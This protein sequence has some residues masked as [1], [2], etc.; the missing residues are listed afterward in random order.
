M[1]ELDKVQQI[2]NESEKEKEGLKAQLTF[3]IQRGERLLLE[4]RENNGVLVMISITLNDLVSGFA[5][6]SG[7]ADSREGPASSR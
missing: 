7:E 4:V 3:Q 1:N 5:V 6:K 2:N